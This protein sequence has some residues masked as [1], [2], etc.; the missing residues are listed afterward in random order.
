MSKV[1]I[2]FNDALQDTALKTPILILGSCRSVH[3]DRPKNLSNCPKNGTFRSEKQIIQIT[4]HFSFDVC[5]S[6]KY[7]KTE[8]KMHFLRTISPES[9]SNLYIWSVC[10]NME[11]ET[12]NLSKIFIKCIIVS[13]KNSFI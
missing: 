5:N 2:A 13:V 11:S 4:Q 1:V 12:L 7:E 9:L 3:F 8:E 10:Q 6:I